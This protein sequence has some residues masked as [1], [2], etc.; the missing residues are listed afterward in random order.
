[1]LLAFVFVLVCICVNVLWCICMCVWVLRIWAILSSPWLS[2]CVKVCVYVFP[3][4]YLSVA[5][6]VFCTIC[7]YLYFRFCYFNC[8]CFVLPLKMQFIA[9][10]ALS[11]LQKLLLGVC[12]LYQQCWFKSYQS[13]QWHSMAQHLWM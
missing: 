13:K 9:S 4:I 2:Y 3:H 7:L 8:F 1:M 10:I 6:F 12:M 5:A 11:L